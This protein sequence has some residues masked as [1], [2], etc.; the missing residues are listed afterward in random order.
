MEA[1]GREQAAFNRAEAADRDREEVLKQA[2][3]RARK[4]EKARGELVRKAFGADSLFAESRA[5]FFDAAVP[6]M[7]LAV[8][9]RS[10]EPVPSALCGI[11]GMV[12]CGTRG[13]RVMSTWWRR[14]CCGFLVLRFSW[15]DTF[16]FAMLA[17][18]ET[19]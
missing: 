10:F 13:T 12:A 11:R 5:S 1:F 6:V 15:K 4:I 2:R 8:S 9:L 3:S 18:P 14:S 16:L 19:A 7:P 17:L